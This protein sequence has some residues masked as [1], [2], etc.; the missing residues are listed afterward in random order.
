MALQIHDHLKVIEI[1]LIFAI[2]F[3]Q[4]N[5]DDSQILWLS[6]SNYVL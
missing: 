1:K 2:C 4:E 3:Y 6:W 5:I